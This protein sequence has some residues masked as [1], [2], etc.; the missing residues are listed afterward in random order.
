MDCVIGYSLTIN[1][2]VLLTKIDGF[3]KT[4]QSTPVSTI[5]LKY[6]NMI[7]FIKSDL[8]FTRDSR[9]AYPANRNIITKITKYNAVQVQVHSLAYTLPPVCHSHR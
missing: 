1:P 7:V 5:P 9:L 6:E 4:G 3:T 8:H 2:I